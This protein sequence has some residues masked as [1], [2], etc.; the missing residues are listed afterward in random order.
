MKKKKDYGL[1]SAWV[2]LFISIVV[3]FL[4]YYNL[5]GIKFL[6]G[7]VEIIDYD[8]LGGWIGGITTPF[9]SMAAFILL[10]ITYKSQKEE[11]NE[12]R[13]LLAQQTLSI[14]KQQFENTFFNLLNQQS[15]IV[16]SVDIKRT[17]QIYQPHISP[18]KIKVSDILHGRDCFRFFYK[19]YCT[20]YNRTEVENSSLVRINKSYDVFFKLYQN[21]LSHYFRFLYNII[22]FIDKSSIEDKKNYTNIVRAQLSSHELLI[23]FYNSLSTGYGRERFKPFIEKYQLLKNMP[24]GQLIAPGHRGLYEESAYA[25]PVDVS[26]KS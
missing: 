11:L 3:V 9:L 17:I 25:T 4:P 5:N 8:K 16:K 23:L 6:G 15:E 20:R 7:Q 12:S 13:T 19:I 14:E 2:L 24:F 10:Y 18:N 1:I 22:K 21:D 26:I